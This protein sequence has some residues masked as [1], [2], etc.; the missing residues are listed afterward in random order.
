MRLRSSR[1]DSHLPHALLVVVVLELAIHRLA[2]PSFRP[3]GDVPPPAW[4][5]ALSYFGLFLF[6]FASVLAVLVAIHLL[7]KF[8]RKNA[9]MPWYLGAVLGA[10]GLAF[11]TLA[12]VCMVTAAGERVTF[13]FELTF[14]LAVVLLVL[15]SFLKRREVGATI[16]LL[17]LAIP[18]CI[19]FYAPL[20]GAEAIY[21]GAADDAERWGQWTLLLAALAT[22]YC[23]P[24]KPF[25]EH[26]VRL[27][28]LML[29]LFVGGVGAVLA[30][31]HYADSIELA[32]IGLG[33]KI[34]V[35]SPPSLIAL[36]L[37]ALTAVVWTMAGCLF[38]ESPAR[39][40]IGVGLG[41]VVTGGY[42]FEWPLQYLVG[43]VGLLTISKAAVEVAD[44][45]KQLGTV[46][47]RVPPIDDETWQS[48]VTT[49]VDR[50]RDGS[51]QRE[52]KSLE[53]GAVAN[54]RG[55]NGQVRTHWITQ[56]HGL[57]VRV[58]IERI[59]GALVGVD[60]TVGEGAREGRP[61]W[62]LWPTQ[63]TRAFRGMV[64]HPAPPNC[65]GK[66]VKTGQADF[67][68]H[69]ELCVREGEAVA[70]FGHA[71][72]ERALDLLSGWIARWESGVLRYQVYPGRG[73][74]LD[75]PV[76]ISSL[77]FRDLPDKLDALVEVIELIADVA[78]R[79]SEPESESE[80]ESESEPEPERG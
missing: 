26:A 25:I 67:D 32:S 78:A 16:G 42:A 7:L 53:Q 6:Y 41:L 79:A 61:Q 50:L 44:E 66:V 31:W 11:L 55:E 8:A 43:F 71:E 48:Y 65:E 28:A 39:R 57:P 56:R 14:A 46:A 70:V 45:E 3:D 77:S 51:D 54:V 2:V 10:S 35:R 69:F 40:S 33:F 23:F 52:E 29:A 24:P 64:V 30:K 1:L 68:E 58:T 17:F 20:A 75:H 9:L 60:V 49:I 74:P 38:S 15:F 59:A 4:H 34:G 73:A 63:P 22:P 80:S 13:F 76:P 21:Y 18:L 72:R 27:P 62:T 47:F 36:C 19:H 37:L 12:L 5:T